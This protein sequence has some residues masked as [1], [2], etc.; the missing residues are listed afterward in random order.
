M[1]NTFDD[2]IVAFTMARVVVPS[3]L[4]HLDGYDLNRLHEYTQMRWW[5]YLNDEG[6]SETFLSEHHSN[7]YGYVGELYRW[8][9]TMPITLN[10]VVA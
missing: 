1:K 9:D 6:L 8:L 10:W 4:E 5:I 2:I 7:E 3:Y